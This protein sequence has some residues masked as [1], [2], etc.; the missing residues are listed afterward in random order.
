MP[1]RSADTYLIWSG[2]RLTDSANPTTAL[3][4]GLHT[5]S[6]AQL[7]SAER[8]RAR[9][10]EREREREKER[11]RERESERARE[12]ARARKR[13]SLRRALARVPGRPAHRARAA[14]CAA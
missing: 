13:D 12:S 3:S 11:E 5:R 9:E 1:E 6:R 10:R 7:C 8:E 4:H 2:G 14:A